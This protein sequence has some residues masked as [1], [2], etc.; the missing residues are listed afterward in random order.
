MYLWSHLFIY[1]WS[2]VYIMYNHRVQDQRPPLK[3]LR[4]T[5][6]QTTQP[7]EP[8]LP[9]NPAEGVSPVAAAA[10]AEIEFAADGSPCDRGSGQKIRQKCV[11]QFMTQWRRRNQRVDMESWT[12]YRLR[13]ARDYIQLPSSQQAVILDDCLKEEKIPS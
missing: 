3:R 11:T 8:V 4:L 9:V 5:G 7:V 12:H 2:C 13:C 6:K 10:A 1:I